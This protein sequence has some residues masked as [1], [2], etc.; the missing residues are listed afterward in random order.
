MV[1]SIDVF[2]LFKGTHNEINGKNGTI[3]SPHYPT[4]FR[5]EEPYTWRI[6]VDKDYVLILLLNHIIDVDIPFIKVIEILKDP[7][8]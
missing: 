4:K 1:C 8:L 6:T 3:Q 5:T 2:P 7:W